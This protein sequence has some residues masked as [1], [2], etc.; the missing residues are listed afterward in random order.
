MRYSFILLTV[1]FLR[2]LGASP[3]VEAYFSKGNNLEEALIHYIKTERESIKVA[4]YNL[5]LP[6]VADAL[7]DAKQRG[8]EVEIVTNGISFN[9][10]K[11]I[12][13]PLL[14][15]GIEVRVWRPSKL[16]RGKGKIEA[17]SSLMHNKFFIFGK[18][19]VWTGSFNPTRRG[20][21]RNAENAV[22]ISD[23]KV[24]EEFTLNFHE[25]KANSSPL[26]K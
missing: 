20:A 19:A 22:Y 12:F 25:L 17:S 21:S 9:K 14:N 16:R 13:S 3:T 7:V 10:Q 2:A 8:V 18:R 1:F 6:R 26:G 23:Q 24:A 5:A 11:K 4:I 15:G